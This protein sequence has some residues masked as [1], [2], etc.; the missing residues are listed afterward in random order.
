[1]KLHMM[2]SLL[3]CSLVACSTTLTANAGTLPMS[4]G[5]I[6]FAQKMEQPEHPSGK[7]C[8]ITLPKPT[9]DGSTKYYKMTDVGCGDNVATFFK[10]NNVPSTTVVRLSSEKDCSAGDWRFQLQ[11]I[12]NPSSTSWVN[13]KTL[14]G[15]EVNKVVVPGM[16]LLADEYD[17]GN[18]EGKLSCVSVT[19]AKL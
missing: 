4:G 18:I 12:K 6:E 17:H 3:A 7:M 19:P 9:T 11:A 15:A 2:M 14:R 8:T 10:F 13:I 16:L 5:T 1:M